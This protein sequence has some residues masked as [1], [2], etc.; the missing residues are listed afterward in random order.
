MK[1]RMRV[2]TE[3]N[4]NSLRCPICGDDRG[5]SNLWDGYSRYLTDGEEFE[6]TCNSCD[7]QVTC[8]V[9]V[10]CRIEARPAQQK[11]PKP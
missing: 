9:E 5:L 10:T 7:G 3:G 4:Q 11:E 6:A 1:G 8:S 2:C